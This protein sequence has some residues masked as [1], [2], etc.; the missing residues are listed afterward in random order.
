MKLDVVK[1][2]T[3]ASLKSKAIAFILLVG[4]VLNIRGAMRYETPAEQLN[5]IL[6]NSTNV[7]GVDHMM[8]AWYNE[9]VIHQNEG[10]E[11]KEADD[12]AI[13][14]ALRTYKLFNQKK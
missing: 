11:M 3:D 6:T 12:L 13:R 2:F 10:M 7:E 4:V 14:S 5:N 9:F 8:I 1:T